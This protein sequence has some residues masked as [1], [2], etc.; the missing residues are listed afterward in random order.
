MYFPRI[1]I[2]CLC[3]LSVYA[4][5]E[6]AAKTNDQDLKRLV[7]HQTGKKRLAADVYLGLKRQLPLDTEGRLILTVFTHHQP[8]DHKQALKELG[9]DT[10]TVRK[11]FIVCRID[12]AQAASLLEQWWVKYCRISRS[13]QPTAEPRGN[14]IITAGLALANGSEYHTAGFKG[15]GIKVGIIDLEWENYAAV[16][17][18][19]E[20]KPGHTLRVCDETGCFP[21]SVSKP[22]E[23]KKSCPNS[24]GAHGAA[25]YEIIYDLAPDALYYLVRLDGGEGSFFEA[26]KDLVDNYQVHII[27]VSLD[28][29]PDAGP[30]DGRDTAELNDAVAYAYN[31]GVLLVK[32]AGNSGAQ[33]Y[34]GS[35]TDTDVNSKHEFVKK[36]GTTTES[37]KLMV[38]DDQ[39]NLYLVWDGWAEDLTDDATDIFQLEVCPYPSGACVTYAHSGGPPVINATLN[40]GT[41]TAR[42]QKFASGP[43]TDFRLVLSGCGAKGFQNFGQN[44]SSIT[45]PT[46]SRYGLA[47]GAVGT[48]ESSSRL[49]AIEFYSS[50]GPGLNGVIKPDISSYARVSTLS[51]GNNGF[52]GT[53]ASAPHVAGLAAIAMSMNSQPRGMLSDFIVPGN[54]GNGYFQQHAARKGTPNNTY[55]WGIARLP[56]LGDPQ[57]EILEPLSGAPASVRANRAGER[58]NIEIAARSQSGDFLGGLTRDELTITVGGMPAFINAILQRNDRYVLN[59]SLPERSAGQDTLS[60]SAVI[61]SRPGSDQEADAVI[62]S[63]S[64]RIQTDTMVVLDRSGSMSGSPIDAAKNAANL[65]VDLLAPG[66]KVGVASYSGSSRLDYPLTTI[67]EPVDIE[68]FRDDMESGSGNWSATST[69]SLIQTDS[70]G[71]GNS[72]TDSPDANYPNNA[73]STLTLNGFHDLSSLPQPGLLFWSKHSLESDYDRGHLEVSTDGTTWDD[74]GYVSGTQTTWTLYGADLQDYAGQAV[75][76]RFRLITDESFT[77]DGWYLDDVVLSNNFTDT[78]MAARETINNIST[79]GGTSIGAGLQEALNEHQSN[80]EADHTWTTVLLTDGQETLSPYVADILP[81]VQSTKTKVYTIGLG[82]SIDEN[83]LRQIADSTGGQYFS[84]PTGNDLQDIYNTIS[85]EVLDRETLFRKPVTITEGATRMES[86]YVDSSTQ[87]VFISITWPIQGDDINLTLTSPSGV[88]MTAQNVPG[89]VAYTEGATYVSYR[90]SD[91]EAGRWMMSIHG[92]QVT[93]ARNL[94]AFREKSLLDGRFDIEEDLPLIEREKLDAYMRGPVNPGIDV[95][96]QVQGEAELKMEVIA[97]AGEV[98]LGTPLRVS[99]FINESEQVFD[100]AAMRGEI[101]FPDGTSAPFNN[102]RDD[103]QGADDIAGDG[104]FNGAFIAT[105]QQ[106]NHTIRVRATGV[107]PNLNSFERVKNITVVVQGLLDSDSDGMPDSYEVG[108]NVDGQSGLDPDINDAG[109]D[110]D[111]DLLTNLEE[112]Q[113][114]SHPFQVDSDDDGLDDGDEVN[115]RG[116][117][118][119]AADTDGGGQNDGAEVAA[120][121]DPLNP[122]DDVACALAVTLPPIRAVGLGPYA[123][124]ADL[125]CQRLGMILAW[126]NVATGEYLEGDGSA[127]LSD[128]LGAGS[129]T[130]RAVLADVYRGESADDTM[131]ILVPQD[132]VYRDLNGD[133]CNTVTDWRALAGQQWRS[134]HADR[135]DPNGDGIVNL[136]DFFYINIEDGC[137]QP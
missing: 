20:I 38:G 1:L 55:G 94:L 84:A 98:P 48:G 127:L 28:W 51:Y 6:P 27:S 13:P 3:I 29:S 101:I 31:H 105:S 114:G 33:T 133:G 88:V 64:A 125:P 24:K 111:G 62:F 119:A 69:W 67:G 115:N 61:N 123:V 107:L 49:D 96:L 103:G 87:E 134:V 41:Y 56:L 46:E 79:G 86:V 18:S 77:Y 34:R 118:P 104:I 10:Y 58:L 75:Q 120:G 32:A 82:S 71:S 43:V 116:T 12:P 53:S 63:N 42:V 128:G 65:F 130:L 113:R 52:S 23:T 78:R 73:D 70:H 126:Q 108:F 5:D 17:N 129:T 85:G 11:H 16:V 81:Q 4:T 50:R 39:A 100:L 106:G 99:A 136:L 83:L 37:V 121:H 19:G 66:D 54:P 40:K 132:P 30:L 36:D 45:P 8:G 9:I 131:R 137:Q 91:P 89:N 76:F 110:P 44:A 2:F 7:Q 90:I 57:I 22:F 124:E 60:V 102:F 117:S 80:G 14:S 97:E 72:W 26:V 95:T 25:C 59:L 122:S 15:Q 135:S 35:Y 93:A 21:P 74:L 47:V 112:F 92:A 109:L 68:V